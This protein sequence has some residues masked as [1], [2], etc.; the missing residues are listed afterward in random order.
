M[1]AKAELKIQNWG[2]NLAVRIPAALAKAARVTSGQEV[3]VEVL[4]GNIVVK[5]QGRPPRL[6]LAQK[7][8][9]FDPKL[10]GGDV[11]SD[12]PVGKEFR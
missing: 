7:L 10:H 12:T 9:A 8:K 5:P 3:T 1:G 4:D 2:N 11:M 6:T